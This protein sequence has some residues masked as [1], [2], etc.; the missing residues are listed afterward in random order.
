VTDH[1]N[2]K[3]ISVSVKTA[4]E[5]TGLSRS[6]IWKLLATGTV[7]SVSVG[8]KRLVKYESLEALLK[9]SA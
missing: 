7:E 1:H 3:P 6:T 9:S 2:V 8:R 5:L 4:T